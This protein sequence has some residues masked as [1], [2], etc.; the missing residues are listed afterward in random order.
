MRPRNLATRAYRLQL[1]VLVLVK[2]VFRVREGWRPPAIAKNRIPAGMV[3]IQMRTED[4][5]DVFQAQARG[6]Q[7]VEPGLLGKV[8]WGRIALVVAGARVDQDRVPGRA[9]EE[10]L[11][12]DHHTAGW[13]PTRSA[14]PSTASVPQQKVGFPIPNPAFCSVSKRD[15]SARRNIE[16]FSDAGGCTSRRNSGRSRDRRR[17][18]LAPQDVGARSRDHRPEHRLWRAPGT[19]ALDEARDGESPRPLAFT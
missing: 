12:G 6:V 8:V 7:I 14:T 3:E 5:R 9:H 1:S 10:R 18:G 11:V 19:V 17:W 15:K 4:V 2:D 16:P 13:I